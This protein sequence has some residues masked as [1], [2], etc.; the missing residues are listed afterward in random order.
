MR[1]HNEPDG[2]QDVWHFHVHV[3]PRYKD[4]KLYQNHDKKRYVDKKDRQQYV[5]KLKEFLSIN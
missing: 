4:D 1:Q 2:G 5:N 3:F